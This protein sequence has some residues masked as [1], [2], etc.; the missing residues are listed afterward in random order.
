MSN[1]LHS[2]TGN[3]RLFSLF[4]V[5]FLDTYHPKGAV[6]CQSGGSCF[7]FSSQGH[8]LFKDAWLLATWPQ[9]TFL[10]SDLAT[11]MLLH[12][13][14]LSHLGHIIM[15]MVPSLCCTRPLTLLSMVTTEQKTN[16]FPLKLEPTST[17][18]LP[19]WS[20]G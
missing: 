2:D 11:C 19:W 6:S 18:L 8:P 7:S 4:F 12:S 9:P 10:C 3:S 20:S 13:H 17:R 15:N 5:R 1:R 14:P 16:S